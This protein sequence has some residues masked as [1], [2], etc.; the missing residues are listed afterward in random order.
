MRDRDY[1]ALPTGPAGASEKRPQSSRSAVF[2]SLA[3][4]LLCNV[5]FASYFFILS[6]KPL[7]FPEAGYSPA[8]DMI[9]YKTVKF[10]RGLEDDIPIY[11]RA[12]SPEVDKAWEDLY[13]YA[14]SRIPKSEAAKMTNATWP[15]LNEEGNHVIALELFHQLH[16][17]DMIRQ[18]S[19]PGHNYTLLSKIHLRHCIGAIRQALMCY[20]DIS[21]IVWQW[22]SRY[23]EAE[24]RDDILHT[25]RDFD[26]LRGWAQE[27]SLG[28]LP[29]LSVYIEG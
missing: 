6:H 2:L 10:H 16:C 24:Q 4:S 13:V 18:Q 26:K 11:E 19:H 8:Q 29:D 28:L 15:I 12:P 27:H 14:A 5:V 17:L 23:N 1:T 22:S 25:C 9:T 3:L 20:A 21:P 7:I